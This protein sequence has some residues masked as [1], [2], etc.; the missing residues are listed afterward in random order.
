MPDTSKMDQYFVP[1]SKSFPDYDHV[2]LTRRHGSLKSWTVVWVNTE[3]IM[4]CFE[5][6]TYCVPPAHEWSSEE[7]RD[8][9]KSLHPQSQS[10]AVVYLPCVSIYCKTII[11]YPSLLSSLGL[12]LFGKKTK[13]PIVSYENGRYRSRFLQFAGAPY[14]PVEVSVNEASLLREFCG[15]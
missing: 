6:D 2:R 12:K 1:L 9:L 5:R 13:V 10:K 14:F 4:R 7:L 3:K 11:E 8:V 15:I